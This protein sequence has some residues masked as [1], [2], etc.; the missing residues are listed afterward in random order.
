[1]LLVNSPPL[2]I[3]I[4]DSLR[5]LSLLSLGKEDCFL[6]LPLLFLSLFLERIVVLLDFLLLLFG[7]IQFNYFLH[8]N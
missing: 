1:M 7:V 3:G 5:L 2:S 6:D 8:S 4:L